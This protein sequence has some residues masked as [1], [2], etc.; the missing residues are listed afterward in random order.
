MILLSEYW[1]LEMG[2]IVF[3]IGIIFI[4]EVLVFVTIEIN[5]FLIF[6]NGVCLFLTLLS[7]G[8]ITII[9]KITQRKTE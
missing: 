9:M 4:F 5:G 3:V 2:L 7:V 6:G 1:F 8:A